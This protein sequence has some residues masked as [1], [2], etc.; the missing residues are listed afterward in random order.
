MD[1]LRLNKISLDE[2]RGQIL[3]KTEGGF[4][5]NAALLAR[6]ES[7]ISIQI[8]RI[9]GC[10]EVVLRGYNE[11]NNTH[12]EFCS[13]WLELRGCDDVFLFTLSLDV[14]LHFIDFSIDTA[15]GTVYGARLC[16][17]VIKFSYLESHAPFQLTVSEFKHEPPTAFY[18]GIIYHVFVD[19]FARSSK[20]IEK[21]GTLIAD[22][23]KGIP[24]YPEYPGAHL[25]NNTFWGGSLY[26]IIDKLDYIKALG[27]N[28]IYLSPIF[29]SPSN[30]KYD[31]ADYMK[32]DEAFGGDDALA[33]L[34]QESHARGIA[35]ILDGV[36]N[37]TGADSVYFNR[38][39]SYDSLGAYQ[40]KDSP[41][42]SWYDF[43]K[44]P[45]KYT[46]WWDIEI[47]PR[48]NTRKSDCADFF[49][50][51]NGVIEKYTRMGVDGFR[52]DV[53]DE[54]SDD[55]ISRIKSCLSNGRE[56]SILYGE[57]WE[58]ASNKIAYSER[59]RYYL[60]SELDGVM[61]YPVRRG[62]IDFLVSKR[63]DTLEY[64]LS[65]IIYNAPKR[66]RDAQMN[67]L[68]THDTERILTVLGGDS[69]EGLP[70]AELAKKRMTE[71]QRELA[72]QRLKL[73]YTIL[74]TVPGIPTVFYGDEAGLEGYG[75]PFNRMPYPWGRE[76]KEILDFYKKIGIIRRENSVYRD[77]EFRLLELT[78]D[79]LAFSRSSEGVTL[80]TVINNGDEPVSLTLSSEADALISNERA[81]DFSISPYAPQILRITE[82]EPYMIIESNRTDK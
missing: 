5:S 23:S 45:D 72:F 34:I 36:F 69:A 63:T 9:L 38:Y 56:C 64:A 33:T 46:C 1:K 81:K 10:K 66:I 51:K 50:G 42:Y 22:Y 82:N 41:Y 80:I 59:K 4:T 11:T 79:L 62:I 77:G 32:V 67:L 53:A 75:D 18:G 40:S 16:S 3:Y 58:D 35:I 70:N 43:K 8:P 17:N 37:H 24:E 73:A 7:L 21:R 30:H 48:I 2:L 44:H 27:V 20:V 13:E 74:A 15:F 47:L 60:G 31:T 12:F 28:A 76:N 14:G 39:G 54:L 6:E 78:A 61:N 52:L 65:D 29:E 68:G 57:V 25:K 26:G 71:E 55:F 19:R 49:I